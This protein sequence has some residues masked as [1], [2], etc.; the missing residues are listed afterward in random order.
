MYLL[1]V[2]S[3]NILLFKGLVKSYVVICFVWLCDCLIVW[4]IIII[5]Y[6]KVIVLKDL[7]FRYLFI[8]SLDFFVGFILGLMGIWKIGFL[9]VMFIVVIVSNSI[10][11]FIFMFEVFS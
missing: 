2:Y 3:G 10:M 4:I 9:F 1:Y 8:I 5:L 7:W 11:F 6:K